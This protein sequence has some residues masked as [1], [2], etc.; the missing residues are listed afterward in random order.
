[1]YLFVQIIGIQIVHKLTIAMVP[2]WKLCGKCCIVLAS[3]REVLLSHVTSYFSIEFECQPNSRTRT[4][5]C[6]DVYTLVAMWLAQLPHHVSRT[7]EQFDATLRSSI[8][9][10]ES[11]AFAYLLHIH[12]SRTAP[13]TFTRQYSGGNW[14]LAI[15][16]WTLN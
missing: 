10:T 14:Y 5:T 13:A 11:D 6:L 9:S 3:V 2:R 7:S 16:P 15:Y 4:Y 12:A 1:M 8:A